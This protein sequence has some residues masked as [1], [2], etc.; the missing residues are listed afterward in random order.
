LQI[1][2]DDQSYMLYHIDDVV[3][4]VLL[5]LM[6]QRALKRQRVLELEEKLASDLY[7]PNASRAAGLVAI[8]EFWIC[9]WEDIA[10]N[11]SP[12]FSPQLPFFNCH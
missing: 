9:C 5:W 10:I 4:I 7:G 2:H 3:L 8:M 12:A 1:D 11:P 6:S